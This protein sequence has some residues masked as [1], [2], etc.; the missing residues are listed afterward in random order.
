MTKIAFVDARVYNIQEHTLD[1]Q[2]ILLKNHTLVG[3]GYTPDDDEG[4][5]AYQLRQAIIIPNIHDD[6]D[7]DWVCE[8]LQT[9]H[10]Q[11]NIPLDTLLPI[12]FPPK[13]AIFGR[14]KSKWG[15]LS[16]PN[17]AIF[18]SQDPITC[19]AVIINGDIVKMDP[20]LTPTNFKKNT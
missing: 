6:L 10:I 2:N 9:Q 3:L 17:F 7:T 14:I 16:K 4:T 20:T 13:T 8:Q 1:R 15:L 12:L 11:N 19:L 18:H 5:T